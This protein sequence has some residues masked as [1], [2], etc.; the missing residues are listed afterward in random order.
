MF[1]KADI[2]SNGDINTSDFKTCL[3]NLNLGFTV[4]ELNRI[5]RYVEKNSQGEINYGEFIK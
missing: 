5:T 4:N 2:N 1:E 3:L